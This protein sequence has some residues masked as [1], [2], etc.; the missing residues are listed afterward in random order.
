[1]KD[2]IRLGDTTTHGGVVLEAFSRTDLNGKPIAGVGHKV[3]CPLCK[4]IFPIV[5][6]SATDSVDGIAVALDGM[7]TACGAALIASGPKGAVSR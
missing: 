3:S 7:K 4:G 5:E 1:M 2:I 6:G